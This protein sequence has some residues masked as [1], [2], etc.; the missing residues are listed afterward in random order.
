MAD[1]KTPKEPRADQPYRAVVGLDYS[2]PTGKAIRVEAG[3][4][5]RNLPEKSVKWLLDQGLIEP[6]EE[7]E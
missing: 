2:S 7:P 4:V 6:I 5:A 1:K 3:R